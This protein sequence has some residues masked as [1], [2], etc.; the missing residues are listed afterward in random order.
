MLSNVLKSVFGHD[1]F[2]S[3]IQKQ[4]TTAIYKAKQDVF[5][6]MPTGSGKSLCFQLPAIMKE[7]K[8][9]IVFSPLLALMKNQIDF[10]VSKKINA[11]SLNST[12]T[13]KERN[14][15]MKDLMSSTPKVKLLYVTPEMGAQSHFQ[16]IILKLK[17]AKTLSY[18]VIDEAHCLSQ[19]GHDFRPT[20]R[21]LGIFKKLCPNIPVIALTATAA[22]EV[23]DDILHSLSMKDPLIFSVPVFRSNLYYDVWFVE[24]IDK[25]YEHLKDYILDILGIPDD[26]V[27][28]NKR[29]CGIIYCRK[30]EA[31]E[32]VANKLTAAGIPTLSYHAGLKKQERNDVQNKWTCGEVPV[33]AAT[34]SFGMGVDK[35]SVRFVIHWTV[36]QNIAAY[37][38]E[39]GRAGRDG[40]PAFCR[41]YFSN[42]ESRAIAFLIKEEVNQKNTEVVKVRWKNF[43]KSVAYC[44]ETKCRH[45]VFS[46]YFGDS[47]PPCKNRCDV[48]KDIAAVKK[49]ISEFEL[50]QS[51]PQKP[52]SCLDG[53]AL[54]KYDYAEDSSEGQVSKEKLEAE[55]KREAKLFIQQQFALRGGGSKDDEIRKK[56]SEDARRAHVCAAESTDRKIKGLTVQMREHFYNQLKSALFDNY[57][58]VCS[59]SEL[60]LH[61]DDMHNAAYHLEY[62]I[63]CS[64]KVANKYKFD[65]SKLLSTIRKHTS[66][67]TIHDS[68]R[69]YDIISQRADATNSEE[70]TNR[71]IDDI[72]F[73]K[74]L[75]NQ[76]KKELAYPSF[77]TAL[78]IRNDERKNETIDVDESIDKEKVDRDKTGF[79][80]NN[81]KQFQIHGETKGTI[82][83]LYQPHGFI[84]A[85][86]LHGDRTPS[87]P[88]KSS[89][90]SKTSS[91][92]CSTKGKRNPQVKSVYEQLLAF[93]N[94][95]P[96]D[97]PVIDIDDKNLRLVDD[98]EETKSCISTSTI[99]I[100]EKVKKRRE[101]VH[102]LED[103]T[104]IES[105]K[106]AKLIETESPMSIEN[107]VNNKAMVSDHNTY[108]TEMNAKLK[109]FSVQKGNPIDDPVRESTKYSKDHEP[110]K[111][112]SKSSNEKG[113]VSADKVTQF[114]TAEILKSCLMK[115]YRTDRIPDRTTF[116]KI[117]REMH[118]KLL[119]RKI[120]DKDGIQH[121]VKSYILK[122]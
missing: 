38:Q 34:C 114:K 121:F 8:V 53:I 47:P 95:V 116:S 7:G 23:K 41:V 63:L 17:K 105:R 57:N 102:M 113:L 64:T 108:D 72:P 115:Y 67:N 76:Q 45:S 27:P 22:K 6:C 48:C 82:S 10:L 117:C 62:S 69:N 24:T 60:F 58:K 118:H 44:I 35:G 18:F 104:H 46:K 78:E 120:F 97:V 80:S 4:A 42:Q 75:N 11:S 15:I 2:K 50:C 26:S 66:N 101:S 119:H 111:K 16:D 30:K 25:P 83:K 49:R 77:K 28:K 109:Q 1:N 31:T 19:W 112:A 12:T 103:N 33:I 3:D 70:I 99:D 90:K 37:Y 88:V 65:I 85:R 89:S 110:F 56:N 107:S 39:S 59:T 43:E 20:Y 93:S 61:E 32:I 98:K 106:R 36:P 100:K 84:C 94:V 87:S 91:R 96:K 68:L 73:D 14:A 81:M 54:A 5:V 51:R 29:G 71:N 92:G 40:G 13:T 21:Q 122:S 52:Q 86:K 9:A 74:E 55:A 79:S